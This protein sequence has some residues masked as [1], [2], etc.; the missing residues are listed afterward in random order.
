M[1]IKPIPKSW[2]IHSIIYEEYT[3]ND[4]WN[5]PIYKEPLTIDY[6]RFDEATVFSRDSKQTVIV[7]DGIIFVDMINSQTFPEFIEQSK[8]TFQGKPRVLKKVIPCYY[9]QKNKIH[10]YE[11]EVI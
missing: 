10:H 1:R 2:L 8:I 4:E 3:G 11:L 9:P 6:V 7:A 5:R